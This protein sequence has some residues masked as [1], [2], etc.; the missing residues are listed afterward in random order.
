MTTLKSTY[1]KLRYLVDIGCVFIGHGL[2][3]DFK[4]INIV[5]PP[6]QVIDTVLLFH[7]PHHRMVSLKFLAWHFLDK[8]IQGITHDSIEDAVTALL[9]Y[10]K[11]QQLKGNDTLIEALNGLYEKGK[12]CNWKIPEDDEVTA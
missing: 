6:E 8:K 10:K 3:N 9:L 2:K 4:V 12:A 11:Y 7:L 1:K 5:V